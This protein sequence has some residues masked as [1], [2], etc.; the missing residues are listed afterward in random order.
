MTVMYVMNLF[1]A[2]LCP[3][4]YESIQ[5]N[6]S[7]RRN[8]TTRSGPNDFLLAVQRAGNGCLIDMSLFTCSLTGTLINV[9]LSILPCVCVSMFIY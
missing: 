1:S 6:S 5:G 7:L 3:V 8:V 4:S 9:V 2:A